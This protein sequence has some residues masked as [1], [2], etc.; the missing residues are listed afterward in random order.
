MRV[1][2]TG[3]TGLIGTALVP[4]LIAA[5]HQVLGLTR[6][7]SG[8]QTLLATGAEFVR[9]DLKESVTIRNAAAL[10]DAVVHCAFDHDPAHFEA[11]G[12]IER[13][14]IAALGAAL[15]GSDRP[16][17]VSTGLGLDSPKLP[18]TE[19]VDPPTIATSPRSPEQSARALQL[20]G[21]NVTDVRVPQVHNE[22]KQGLV[23]TL[24]DVARQK[25]VSAHVASG[26]NL[27]P[28]AHVLDVA[29]L[30]RLALERRE[31]ARYHAVAEEGVTLRDI[32]AAIGRGLG[33]PVVSIPQEEAVGHFGRIGAYVGMDLS[34]S[35]EW[36]R[37]QL[38]WRPTGPGLLEDLQNL[39]SLRSHT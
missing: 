38:G 4:E 18:I 24:I 2:L 25:G 16:M 31:P 26:R 5:G 21:I 12:E 33:V 9:G 3:A 35:S 27:W 37:Q 10:C 39:H 20:Q 14:A 23:T 36:T 1:F 28:A 32:A 19:D 15:Q 8:V 34:A 22:V 6:S 30:Y 29:R 11:N 7:E 13:Q 17:I